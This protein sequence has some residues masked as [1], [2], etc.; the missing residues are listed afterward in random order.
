MVDIQALS[1]S[2]SRHHEDTNKNINSTQVS[3]PDHNN[4]QKPNY[5]RNQNKT[6]KTEITTGNRKTLGYEDTPQK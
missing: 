6:T 5:Y 4:S 1:K 2:N 3:D